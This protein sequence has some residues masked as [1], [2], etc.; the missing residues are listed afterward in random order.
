MSWNM[1][2]RETMSRTRPRADDTR[3]LFGVGEMR[4]SSAV[5]DTAR[6]LLELQLPFVDFTDARKRR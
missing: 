1:T 6:K 5:A 4:L 2:V 3:I